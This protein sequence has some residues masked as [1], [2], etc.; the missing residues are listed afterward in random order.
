MSERG[1]STKQQV[2]G[3]SKRES[4]IFGAENSA[5]GMHPDS[6]KVQGIA[7]MTPPADKQQQ[8][9]EINVQQLNI[10]K[11]ECIPVGCVPPLQ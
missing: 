8:N 5:D 6:K 9:L 10:F 11:Q 4:H 7:E 3:T 1:P 2:T